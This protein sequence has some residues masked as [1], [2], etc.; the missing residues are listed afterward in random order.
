M[1]DFEIS[2]QYYLS[3]MNTDFNNWTKS[4]FFINEKDYHLISERNK[5]TVEMIPDNDS[6]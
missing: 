1:I 2:G 6:T 5:K 3:D 4:K